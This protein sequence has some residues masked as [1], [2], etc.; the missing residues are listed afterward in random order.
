MISPGYLKNS[1]DKPKKVVPLIDEKEVVFLVEF[2]MNPINKHITG[3]NIEIAGG[4]R[5]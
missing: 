5:L 4:V 2:L 1:I 3:Q